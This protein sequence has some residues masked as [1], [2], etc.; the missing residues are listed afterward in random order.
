MSGQDERPRASEKLA[1]N[2]TS[3]NAATGAD[4]ECRPALFHGD[5]MRER[6]CQRQAEDFWKTGL[7]RPLP[8]LRCIDPI[9]DVSIIAA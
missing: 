6:T 2:D 1:R 7:I 8:N 5:L 9:A 4:G 3:D